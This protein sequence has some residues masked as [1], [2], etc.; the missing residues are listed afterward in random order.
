[1]AVVTRDGQKVANNEAQDIEIDPAMLEQCEEGE[2]HKLNASKADDAWDYGAPV[3]M[4]LYDLR[5]GLAKGGLKQNKEDKHFNLNLE[6]KVTGHDNADYNGQ[7]VFAYVSTK[8]G[9]GKEISTA[10]AILVKLGVEIPKEATDK[11]IAMLLVNKM[12][13]EA[14]I[15]QNLLDWRATYNAGTKDNPDWVNQHNTMTDFP[16]LERKENG[17]IVYNHAPTLVTAKGKQELRAQLFVA[18]WGNANVSKVVHKKGPNAQAAKTASAPALAPVPVVDSSST[19][20]LD[21][22]GE[23]LMSNL[24]FATSD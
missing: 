16:I 17:D 18:E 15:R 20:A 12:K 5:L 10:A 7:T 22:G 19:P 11:Q 1:M 2:V 6:C 9:R 3:P 14:I 23:D 21:L 24:Q 8:I 4:G 13:G